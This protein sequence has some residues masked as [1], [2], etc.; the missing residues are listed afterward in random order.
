[1]AKQFDF[2]FSVKEIH[3]FVTEWV[4]LLAEK[5]YAKAYDLVL[6]SDYFG[7]TPLLMESVVNGYGLPYEGNGTKYEVT[8]PAT[9]IGQSYDFDILF[10]DPNGVVHSIEGRERVGEV[11]YNLPLNG[12]WSDLTVTFDLVRTQ[13]GTYLELND[14]HIH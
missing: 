10:Y 3:K 6:L 8:D 7:W 5:D 2:S 4:K 9:A 14:I 12:E 1:M 11:W 13:D